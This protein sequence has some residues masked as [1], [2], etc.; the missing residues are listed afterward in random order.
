VTDFKVEVAVTCERTGRTERVAMTLEE[1]A[2]YQA[3]LETKKACTTAVTDFLASLP[4]HQP[5]LVVSFRGKHLVLTTVAPGKDATV[6]K[7]LHDLTLAEMFNSQSV[8][9]N[10][11]RSSGKRVRSI[12]VDVD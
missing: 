12:S 7:L 4:P 8:E 5:D 1:A 3:A 9:E 6:L 2:A 10:K 11:P